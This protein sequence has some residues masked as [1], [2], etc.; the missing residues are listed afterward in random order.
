MIIIDAQYVCVLVLITPIQ[1]QSQVLL[2]GM[3]VYMIFSANMNISHCQPT[4]YS[5]DECQSFQAKFI[6]SIFSSIRM[7]WGRAFA[8]S[9]FM[10]V[11]RFHW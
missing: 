4:N 5:W 6:F 1:M 10:Y 7:E 9:L 8:E 11:N 2:S 3:I